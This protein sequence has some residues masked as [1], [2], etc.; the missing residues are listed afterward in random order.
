MYTQIEGDFWKEKLTLLQLQNMRLKKNEDCSSARENESSGKEKC[1]S[2]PE[3]GSSGSENSS[4]DETPLSR[5]EKSF[6]K[7]SVLF[8]D[9]ESSL[10]VTETTLTYEIKPSENLKIRVFQ[11]TGAK[12]TFL[13]PS[14]KGTFEKIAD[15]KFPNETF[16]L[17]KH[18]LSHFSQYSQE[19]EEKILFEQKYQKKQAIAF[20]TI[21]A[22]LAQKFEASREVVWFLEKKERGFLLTVEKKGDKRSY[23]LSL[24][25][26][27]KEIDELPL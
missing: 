12:I 1:S 9:Y 7:L 26:F 2:V 22:V 14:E 21:N 18:F 19:L 25:N 17:L 4:K 3:N 6:K 16:F 8:P 23:P 11:S 20:H 15:A 27:L 5:A 24:E 13:A 10:S